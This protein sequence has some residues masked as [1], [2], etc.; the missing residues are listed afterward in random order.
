MFNNKKSIVETLDERSSSVVSIFTKT[1]ADLSQI[2]HE[3]LD[4]IDIRKKELER[5]EELQKVN[6]NF[7]TKMQDLFK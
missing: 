3:V 4:Q 5:L 2:N 7:I 6:D 1:I